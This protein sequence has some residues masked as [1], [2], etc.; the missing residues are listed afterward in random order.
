MPSLPTW[1]HR[2][3]RCLPLRGERGASAIDYGI[4]IAVVAVV[5]ISAVSL[6]G[7]NLSSLLAQISLLF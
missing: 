6:T 3:I 7:G 2:T 1:L 4:M 5:I